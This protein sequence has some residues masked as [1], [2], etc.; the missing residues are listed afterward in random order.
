MESTGFVVIGGWLWFDVF[1]FWT[2]LLV[3]QADEGGDT[4][5]GLGSMREEVQSRG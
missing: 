3:R 4:H 5:A 1:G 2:S